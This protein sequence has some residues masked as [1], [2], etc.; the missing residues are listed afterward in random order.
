MSPEELIAYARGYVDGWNRSDAN[1]EWRDHTAEIQE[2]M[3][4]SE[5]AGRRRAWDEAVRRGENPTPWTPEGDSCT[6]RTQQDRPGADG[7]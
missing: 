5:A 1:A 4:L 3:R 6:A 2:A 7:S